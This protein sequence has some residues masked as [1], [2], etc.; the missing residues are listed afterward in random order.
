MECTVQRLIGWLEAWAPASDAETWDRVGLQIGDPAA[1][2]ERVLVALSLTPDVVEQAMALGADLVVV[3]H[4]VLF[5]PVGEVRWDRPPGRLLR[6]VLRAG[7]AVYASHTNADVAVDGVNGILAGRLGLVD[8]T[9]LQPHPAGDGRGMGRI[10][11][12]PQPLSAPA[13]L[14][15]VSR[16]L[17]VKALRTAGSPPERI[18]R[19]AVMGG[20]GASFLATAAGAGAD[21]FV[22]GDVDYHDALDACAHGLWT[23]DAGHFATE[24]WIVPFW[25]DFLR[26]RAAEAGI[27]IQVQGAD[28]SDPFEFRQ[29]PGTERESN[30][31][32]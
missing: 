24:R 31:A 11:R 26:R 3:H 22:T 21:A 29:A 5:R 14:E 13:F 7:F 6:D 15:H 19:V 12:L 9:P 30:D 23:L 32:T 8:A 2:V 28:E 10:G 25:V 20:S 1:R 18:E 16:C 4:P 27:T 17:G